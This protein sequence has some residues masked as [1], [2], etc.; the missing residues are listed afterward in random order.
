MSIESIHL[1]NIYFCFSQKG[2]AKIIGRLLYVDESANIIMIDSVLTDQWYL[3]I[4]EK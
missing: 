3:I 1:L 4:S 2:H